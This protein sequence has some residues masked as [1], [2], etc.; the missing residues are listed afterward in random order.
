[1]VAA[2]LARAARRAV[3]TAGPDLGPA[4]ELELVPRV[5]GRVDAVVKRQLV[6]LL[7][8]LV[9]LAKLLF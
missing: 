8:R 3:E 2:S 4:A 9:V 6:E 5:V 7:T 1:M